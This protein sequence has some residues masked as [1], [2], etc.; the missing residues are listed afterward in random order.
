MRKL[1]DPINKHLGCPGSTILFSWESH[2]FSWL[3]TKFPN[4]LLQLELLPE[5]WSDVFYI[6]PMISL[7]KAA[8]LPIT[9]TCPGW[10]WC[11]PSSC[12]TRFLSLTPVTPSCPAF[13]SLPNCIV[14]PLKCNLNLTLFSHLHYNQHSPGIQW[15]T[16]C[17]WSQQGSHRSRHSV[18]QTN[19]CGCTYN[20]SVVPL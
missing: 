8:A 14:C 12:Q 1:T 5:F 2:L 17:H 3:W 10:Q 7:C 9:L 13:D 15:W 20:F 18:S 4:S 16:P 11:L 19:H 6:W